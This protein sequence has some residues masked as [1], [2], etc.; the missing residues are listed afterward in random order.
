MKLSFGEVPRKRTKRI[1]RAILTFANGNKQV[2]SY[3]YCLSNIQID[4]S[5]PKQVTIKATLKQLVE[6]V[7]YSDKLH[8][9]SSPDPLTQ[10][11]LQEALEHLRLTLGVFS[12]IRQ[13]RQ[14]SKYWVFRLDLWFVIEDQVGNLAEFDRKWERKKNL[15][16][17]KKTST[18]QLENHI[19][20]QVLVD[21]QNFVGREAELKSLENF[22][23]FNKSGIAIIGIYGMGG[24][25]K[26]TLAKHFAHQYRKSFPDGVLFA[27]LR[28]QEPSALL[29]SF[30]RAYSCDLNSTM[31]IFDKA[32]RVRTIL[33]QKRS[34]LILDNAN[35]SEILNYLLPT[36][37]QCSVIVTARDKDIAP[38][39]GFQEL[40]LEPFSKSESMELLTKLVGRDRIKSENN[41]AVKITEMC[42]N[43][44]LAINIS[45]SLIKFS[46]CSLSDYR[47]S[48]ENEQQKLDIFEWRSR[49][50]RSSFNIT[51]D[52]LDETLKRLLS[53]TSI[54]GGSSIDIDALSVM[55][56]KKPIKLQLEMGGLIAVSLVY[57]N[58]S[59]HYK[60]HPLVKEFA[61]EKLF[62][63]ESNE[64]NTLHLCLARYYL[65]SIQSG[66]LNYDHINDNYGNI[67]EIVY[68]TFKNC[69]F[70][71]VVEFGNIIGD[72][73]LFKGYWNDGSNILRNTIFACQQLGYTQTEFEIRLKLSELAREQADYDQAQE[74]YEACKTFFEETDQKS[75]LAIVFRE[76]GELTRVRRNYLQARKLHQKSLLLNIELDNKKGEAQSLHDLGLIERIFGNYNRAIQLFER[77]LKIRESLGDLL[78][79]SYNYLELGIIARLK[80][81]KKAI[82]FLRSSC[83]EFERFGDK[84]G[85]AYVFR[86]LGEL[87]VDEMN[88]VEADKFHKKSLQLRQE[89]GD[90]RGKAISLYRIGRLNQLQK[91]YELSKQYFL[92]S[93]AIAK[94]LDDKLHKAFNLV[95][96]GELANLSGQKSSAIANW[97]Q[98]LELFNE[99]HVVDPEAIEVK[100]LLMS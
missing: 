32:E 84:R 78:G 39:Q 87:A 59:K 90:Q 12:D 72:F 13:K 98:S 9:E 2:N 93:I 16:S 19:P 77:S 88:Y 22:L 35:D 51:W 23:V 33:S 38:L 82:E 74:Q 45:G 96:L 34:L 29:E 48:F 79:I 57:T 70:K 40:I 99:M 50:L 14:G 20:F 5:G 75:Q 15:V 6:L 21:I 97:R 8:V 92:D 69:Y 66:K 54:F 65:S 11:S 49:S 60:L 26:S 24:V 56:D 41:E 91:N 43:L 89:L 42:G 31:N 44:P 80:K 95:R 81:D 27:D 52:L 64:V 18:P 85:L 3:R 47:F 94:K 71:E 53:T 30:A 100:E 7:S 83:F 73:L 76:L 86:E 1:L 68:W 4:R 55:L 63:R 58:K 17:S 62:E 46:C 28:I 37:G 25:G 61:T 10:W 36:F 67:I